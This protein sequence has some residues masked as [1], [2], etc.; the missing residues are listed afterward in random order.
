MLQMEVLETS[1]KLASLIYTDERT[2]IQEDTID[3]LLFSA[4]SNTIFKLVDMG[5]VFSSKVQRGIL[6]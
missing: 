2:Q 6:A 5:R 4:Y 1:D 3:D